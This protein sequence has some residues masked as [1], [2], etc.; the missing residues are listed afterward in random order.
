MDRIPVLV[1]ALT[2][3]ASIAGRAEA[4]VAW[5]SSYEAAMARARE[6]GRVVFVAVNMDGEGANDH[7]A[8]HVYADKRVQGL[9]AATV[10]L[11]ASRST[12]AA[13]GACKR[14]AGIACEDHVRI[15]ASVRG[16]LVHKDEGG[17]IVAPQHMLLSPTGEV[18]LSVPYLIGVEELVWCLV[19]ARRTLPADA[20]LAMPEDA[21]PPRRLAMQG[22]DAAAAGRALVRPLS[23]EE[24][25]ATIETMRKGWGAIEDMN[26]FVQILATDHPTAIKFATSEIGSGMSSSSPELTC[27]LVRAVASCSP[28]SFWPALEP[29][30]RQQADSVRSEAAAALEQLAAREA[31]PAIRKALSKER[32]LDVRCGLLRALGASGSRNAA[33]TKTL[34]TA[35]KSEDEAVLRVNA[36]LALAYHVDRE[37]VREFLVGALAGEDRIVRQAAALAMAFSR[38]GDFAAPVADAAKAEQDPAVAALYTRAGEVLAGGNLRT[39]A[40][41][42]ERIGRDS[43]RRVRYF[44][45]G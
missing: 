36:V 16:S 32:S 10:N 1:I 38:V 24:L 28:P 5:E 13:S 40:E 21:M 7:L 35:A 33:I 31:V 3:A 45:D 43:V 20:E 42:Y 30:L 25:E 12:H 4:Q 27:M 11:V 15:E 6:E 41:D 26:R 9:T 2:L 17:S 44:G 39:L 18:I 34:L 8:E 23:E 14:F 22:V 37:D 29:C 19:T